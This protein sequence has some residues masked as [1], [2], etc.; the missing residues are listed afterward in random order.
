MTAFHIQMVRCY[1]TFE[2][3]ATDSVIELVAFSLSMKGVIQFLNT[4]VNE[5]EPVT[6]A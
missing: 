6:K 5:S 2:Q 1:K 3:R 4:K